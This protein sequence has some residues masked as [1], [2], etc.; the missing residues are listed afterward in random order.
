MLLVSSQ[1]TMYRGA[2]IA[3][4]INDA[5][6]RRGAI[7]V[8]AGL[9]FIAVLG[10]ALS[11]NWPQLLTARLVLGLGM[12]LN[13]STTSVY[14]AECAPAVIRGGLAVSWQMNT[15]F[16][17]FLGFLAVGPGVTCKKWW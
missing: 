13:A 6:G 11:R 7:F 9:S 3:S 4:P 1:L 17:I 5:I 8:S 2:W 12:G 16:G 10:S 15:A 14:A